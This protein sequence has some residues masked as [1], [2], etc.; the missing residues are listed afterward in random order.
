MLGRGGSQKLGGFSENGGGS[1]GS[2]SGTERENDGIEVNMKEERL[3]GETRVNLIGNSLSKAEYKE[4]LTD[5]D[6]N[7]R[8]EV[9]DSRLG[10][11]GTERETRFHGR[12]VGLSERPEDYWVRGD[13]HD[14]TNLNRSEFVGLSTGE[15]LAWPGAS[16]NRERWGVERNG[17]GGF[18]RNPRAVASQ[19]EYPTFA[20]P[21]EGPSNYQ[22]DS[23]YGYG[24]QIKHD[25]DLDGRRKVE[26]LECNRAELLRKLDKLKDQVCRSRSVENKPLVPVDRTL[27]DPNAGRDVYKAP[28][29]HLLRPPYLNHT[30]GNVPLMNLHNMG[31]TNSH[32]PPRHVMNEL[33]VYDESYQP[34]MARK[35]LHQPL[36]QYPQREPHEYIRRQYM[37]FNQD[38][39]G[40]YQPKTFYH[41]PACSCSLCLEQSW[42]VPP[43]IPAT[44]FGNRRIHQDSINS[45]FYHHDELGA[46]SYNPQVASP[47]QLTSRD[48]LMHKVWTGELDSDA[49]GLGHIRPRLEVAAQ[50]NRLCC[51]PVADG[52]PFIT[53][54]NCFELL[55][56][57]RKLKTTEKNR[58]KLR[59]GGC[60]TIIVFEIANKKLIISVPEET[61]Q[62]SAEAED[63][64]EEVLN[65]SHPSSDGCLDAGNIHSC[66]VDFHNSG[67]NL[68]LTNNRQD[69]KTLSISSSPEA[70]PD[71]VILQGNDSHTTEQAIKDDLSSKHSVSK[72]GQGNNSKRVDQDKALGR[73]TSHQKS[74][75]DMLV[76]TELDVSFNDYLNTCLSQDSVEVSKEKDLPKTNKSSSFFVG[77]IKKSFREFPKP[78]Q[79]LENEKLNVSVNGHPIPDHLVKKAEKLAG[80]IQPGDY[81]YD[82][83]AGFWGVMGHTC[84]GIIPPFIE[85]FNYPM[86]TNCAGGNTGVHVNGRELDQKDLDLLV[87]RGLPPA[88]DKFYLVE[89]SGRVVD[90]DSGKE[91][92]GLGKLAPSVE[93]AKHGFGMKVPRRFR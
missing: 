18:Y 42:Q 45:N 61:K 20:Y 84:L 51:H 11:H 4:V 69:H 74:I 8:E 19:R 65:E 67:H 5:N 90:E 49:D 89:I 14:H 35:P 2:A 46:Q 40:S 88:G 76:A 47:A 72:Y 83:Q 38:P 22:P 6:G 63:G 25:S 92:D 86:P 23:F 13:D 7:V 57:P 15:N 21:Y 37:E 53:C 39:F 1:L 85:E 33:P 17:F 64:S 54:Y 12:H 29:R 79:S 73:I 91:L 66:L 70:S 10:Q 28:D 41:Q 24:E 77:F 68:D 82:P 9:K 16:T 80:P 50:G 36:S 44:V 59:C 52:A 30:H 34:Q 56:L 3:F 78:T 60:S 48:P 27:P 75:K 32:P 26:Q 87:S 93:K 58:R 81:W 71:T 31:P 43:R 55:K 62:I